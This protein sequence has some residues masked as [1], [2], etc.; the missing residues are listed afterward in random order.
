MKTK[1]IYALIQARL[2]STR[3]PGK[4][5]KKINGKESIIFMVDR[6]KKCKNIEDTIILIPKGKTDDKLYNFLKKKKLKVFRGSENDV[7]DRFY[8]C[9]KKLNIKHIL[10]LTSDCPFIDP[11]LVDKIINAYKKGN[12]D[13]VS[14][15][16]FR[17]FPDGM[18]TEIFSYKSLSFAR[19]NLNNSFDRE[20]VTKYFLRSDQLKKKNIFFG[21][22][23]Y[24]NIRLTLDYKE[25]LELLNKLSKKLT[26][27]FCLK[28]IITYYEKNKKIFDINKKFIKEIQSL[29]LNSGQLKWS[30]AKKY[31]AGGNMLFSKRPDRFLPELW[32]A[33]FKK[34]KGCNVYDLDNKKYIDMTIMGVG[35]NILGYANTSVDNAVSNRIKKGNMT[36]LN[37]VE[38]VD[39]A[40]KLIKIHPWADKVR[41]ARSGG[42]ANSIAVRLARASTQRQNIAFCGYHGWH[43]WYL[44]ANL[45]SKKNLNYHLLEGLKVGGVSN[46]LKDTIF[47]FKYNDFKNLKKII[48][49]NNI[50]II[51]MEVV[52]DSTPKSN[53]LKK[54]RKLADEKKIILIFDECTSGFRECLGGIHKKYNVEPDLLMLGKALGNG[55]P[56]TAVLGVEKVMKSINKTFISSTFWTDS[57]GPTAALKT[58]EIM[59]KTKSWNYITKLGGYIIKNWNK[60]SKKHNL[61]IQIS[62]INSLCK[63]NFMSNHN[64]KYKTFITQEMLS[65]GILATNTVYV[66]L[67]HNK[68]IIKKYFIELDKIFAIISKCENHKEDIFK[69]LIVP[70]A[71]TDFTRLN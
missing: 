48:T 40:K 12:Y 26:E 25:D 45:K 28:D 49:K 24:Q 69:Y 43:D 54:V 34:A 70:V 17:S 14:N 39:L 15:I 50:G 32:P 57:S 51:K 11:I 31:I 46:K 36:T 68:S 71:E 60:L 52:R 10:R 55:Y 58:L 29:K 44:A 30:E 41:F 21:K 2:K 61:K 18:D 13:Y 59:E 4:I 62:G 42:E 19:N 7:L 47:P 56:I 66:S 16:I 35:T 8:N 63:F 9:A 53:F 22:K 5:L 37:C 33:Y 23:N 6:L 65:K 64:Q 3:L 67:A 1:K 20:H 38:E 27:N